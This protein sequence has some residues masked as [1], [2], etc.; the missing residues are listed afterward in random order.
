MPTDHYYS[1]DRLNWCRENED[2]K[3]YRFET[4]YRLSQFLTAKLEIAWNFSETIYI[5]EN[6]SYLSDTWLL[7]IQAD[8]YKHIH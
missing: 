6:I 4:F 2:N 5:A 7:R 1:F 8:S 3:S